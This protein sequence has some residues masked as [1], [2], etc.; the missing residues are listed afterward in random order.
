MVF[1]SRNDLKHVIAYV[2]SRLLILLPC[3][4]DSG[5]VAQDITDHV[6]AHGMHVCV[7]M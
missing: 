2:T 6:C 5:G 4:C 1:E 7:N 3:I